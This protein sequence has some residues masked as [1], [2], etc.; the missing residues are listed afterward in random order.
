MLTFVLAV[1]TL[2]LLSYRLV[3]V[4]FSLNCDKFFPSQV[5]FARGLYL[6]RYILDMEDFT[7][8]LDTQNSKNARLSWL[9]HGVIF[10]MYKLLRYIC[11]LQKIP[12]SEHI[13]KMYPQY[14]LYA[15]GEG[16]ITSDIRSMKFTGV[17]VLFVPGSAGS[18]K[19]GMKNDRT[20]FI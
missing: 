2:F 3:G 8:V 9:C 15:Y 6:S 20:L 5:I 17:P 16:H 13:T 18:Y 10:F 4:R 7:H 11:T 19:Q 1:Q 14:G 12:M